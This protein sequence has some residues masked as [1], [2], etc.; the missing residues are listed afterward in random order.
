MH[1]R[2]IQLLARLFIR[3]LI[4]C[5]CRV[6]PE[7]KEGRQREHRCK[8]AGRFIAGGGGHWLRALYT[9]CT[10]MISVSNLYSIISYTPVQ[11]CLSVFDFYTY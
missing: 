9:L 6:R 11:Q 5:R 2:L 8:E 7:F 10:H 4:W 1:Q 3:R